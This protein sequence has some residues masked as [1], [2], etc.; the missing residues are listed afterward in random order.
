MSETLDRLDTEPYIAL[1]KL[2]DQCT[3]KQQAFF[4]RIYP[5]GINGMS[6]SQVRRG[7]EQ[8]EATIKKNTEAEPCEESTK[9]S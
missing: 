4:A 1:N 3:E 2:L 7:I 5:M 6:A 8:C 9:Q